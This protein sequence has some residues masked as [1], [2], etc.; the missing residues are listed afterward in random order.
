M[1]FL[2][3]YVFILPKDLLFLLYLLFSTWI[4][5]SHGSARLLSEGLSVDVC[6]ACLCFVWTFLI[7]FANSPLVVWRYFCQVS[8]W[9]NFEP[10]IMRRNLSL[11]FVGKPCGRH[12]LYTFY[13][14][15]KFIKEGKP[16]VL[17]IGDF[18]YMKIFKDVEVC[19]GEV[20]L[21]LEQ[22][23]SPDQLVAMVRLYFLPEQTTE[24]RKPTTG[25]VINIICLLS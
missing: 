12:G 19:I 15:A 25:E 8:E 18:F 2:C 4:F 3:D 16:S 11:Q 14:A 7:T 21:F 22:R 9:K 23:N 24:G 13:K 17:S 5:L 10:G 20:Q 1:C 6:V